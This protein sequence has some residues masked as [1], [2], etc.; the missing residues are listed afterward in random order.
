MTEDFESFGTSVG[1]KQIGATS[2][3]TLSTAVGSFTTLTDGKGTARLRL[4]RH[5]H[6]NG[7]H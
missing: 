6:R 4:H 5:R 7:H 3:A 2:A 1:V